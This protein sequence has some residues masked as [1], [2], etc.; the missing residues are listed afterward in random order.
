MTIVCWRNNVL[1]DNQLI[2]LKAA[3][4]IGFVKRLSDI[5][6]PS[7]SRRKSEA[8]KIQFKICIKKFYGQFLVSSFR[9]RFHLLSF[10]QMIDFLTAD[11]YFVIIKKSL[12]I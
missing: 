6:A 3:V 2:H 4:A 10:A 12:S 9:A 5:S 11:K 1:H 8:S 7:Q